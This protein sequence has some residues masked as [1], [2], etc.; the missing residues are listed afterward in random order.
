MTDT[1]KA[2]VEYEPMRDGVRIAVARGRHR[3]VLTWTD[4]GY[5]HRGEGDPAE[6]LADPALW[7]HLPED[8]ARAMYEALADHFGGATVDAR[9]LRKDY[10]AERQRV[11]KAL[12]VLADLTRATIHSAIR[13]DGRNT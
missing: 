2:R 5:V 6:Q 9:A 1:T 10:E 4:P 3:Q 7:L 13:S 11:D 12:D 8:V